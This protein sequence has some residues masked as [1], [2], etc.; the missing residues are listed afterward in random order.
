M[1]ESPWSWGTVVGAVLCL[2]PHRP[3]QSHP[4]EG[5]GWERGAHFPFCARP[6]SR[7]GFSCVI[8]TCSRCPC[9]SLPSC[10]LTVVAGLFLPWFSA[11]RPGC[12]VPLPIK[13]E[14]PP[15]TGLYG[16]I[17]PFCTKMLIVAHLLFS[18]GRGY[19]RGPGQSPSLGL[20]AEDPWRESL[21]GY[22]E[23]GEF[24]Q[25]SPGLTGSPLGGIPSHSIAFPD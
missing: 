6:A 2:P 13:P 3:F 16:R 7:L 19:W 20:W 17:L 11:S 18:F 24:W 15:L 22:L 25:Q 10:F 23:G 14:L 4:S 5:R 1:L 9:S 8:L 12:P 21:G